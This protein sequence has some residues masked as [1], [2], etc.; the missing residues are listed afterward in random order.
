MQETSS[1]ERF[2][3]KAHLHLIKMYNLVKMQEMQI[4]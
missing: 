2:N 4:I 3:Y 1:A